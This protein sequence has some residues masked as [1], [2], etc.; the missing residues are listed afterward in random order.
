MDIIIP[1]VSCKDKVWFKNY[2]RFA[3]SKEN[4]MPQIK[5]DY[6]YFYD[7]GTLQYV[8]RGIDKFMPYVDNVFLVVSNIEQV[9]DYVDQSKVKVVLHKDFIP[10][11]YLPTFQANTIEMFMYN[12]PG[13]GEEFVYFNDDTIPVSPIK[14]DELFKDGLP[15]INF[16]ENDVTIFP[17]GRIFNISFGEA[18][19]TAQS[20]TNENINYNGPA[21]R[22]QHA[23]IPYLKSVC[24]E[25]VTLPRHNSLLKFYTSHFRSP[26]N[27]NQYFWSDI[28]Y[29]LNKYVQSD[30][31]LKYITTQEIDTLDINETTKSNQYLCINDF[32]SDTHMLSEISEI[33]KNKLDTILPDRCKYEKSE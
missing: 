32:G 23:P 29:F 33:I 7:Y 22:P 5:L 13:L 17:S 18:R 2:L 10:E 15:C 28:L 3:C 30:L 4:R 26:R 25:V 31:K 9:P 14:Y 6:A 19:N 11:K 21:L 24:D 1:F 12:I 16:I 8:L 20:L 27:L